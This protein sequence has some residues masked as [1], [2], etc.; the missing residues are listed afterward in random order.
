MNFRK[1][2]SFSLIVFILV[3]VVNFSYVAVSLAAYN[4]AKVAYQN[5]YQQY[6]KEVNFYK[7][8]RSQLIEARNK[9]KQFKNA[10]NKK[11]YEDKVRAFLK[12]T[13]NVLE[14]RLQAIERWIS[15]R[16]SLSDEEKQNIRAEIEKDINWLENKKAFIDTA[17]FDQMKNAAREIRNYWHKHRVNVK[18]I[19]ARI[20][21]ARINYA[22]SR[23][24]NISEKISSKIE[25]LKSEGKD[26]AKLEAWLQDF[27]Q[28]IDLAKKARDKAKD[29]YTQI[30]NLSEANQFF[31]QVHQFILEANRYLRDAYKKLKEIVREMKKTAGGVQATPNTQ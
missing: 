25:L 8:V 29:K 10:V 22:I 28:K 26:T 2:F 21:I 30:S 4:K 13:C 5:A 12:T 17:S 3:V 11:D 24:S 18:R 19:I 20:W 27:N 14:R 6:T 15:N 16:K 1:F 31:N 9:Y 7:A 23:F